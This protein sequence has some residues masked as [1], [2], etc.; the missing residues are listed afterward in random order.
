[1]KSSP[2]S[3]EMRKQTEIGHIYRRACKLSYVSQ[4]A[5]SP[6]KSNCRKLCRT[7]S[8]PWPPSLIVNGYP[9]RPRRC[10]LD[11]FC[12]VA[13]REDTRSFPLKALVDG[14]RIICLAHFKSCSSCAQN[15]TCQS[16]T[17]EQ[18]TRRFKRKFAVV[19]TALK[20]SYS[21]I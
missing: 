18:C 9:R 10:W 8:R 2:A 15:Q 19:M 16:W 6:F 3:F 20:L 17:S 12:G 5:P 7:S 13:L 1:M 11:A 4:G 21:L 14:L